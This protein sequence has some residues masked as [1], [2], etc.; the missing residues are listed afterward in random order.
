MVG[1]TCDRCGNSFPFC[2]LDFHHRDPSEK[3][4][5]I[6]AML[7]GSWEKILQEI[8]KC[9]LLCA[10]CHRIVHEELKEEIEDGSS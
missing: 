2:A 9:D 8:S 1:N 10:C 6:S 5:K 3:D 7:S 4:H